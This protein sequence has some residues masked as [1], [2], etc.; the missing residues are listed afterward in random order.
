MWFRPTLEVERDQD[1]RYGAVPERR[2]DWLEGHSATP[3]AASPNHASGH[4]TAMAARQSLDL[5]AQACAL[6]SH[7]APERPLR[8]HPV[9]LSAH[10][11]IG[12]EA[13]RE[14]PRIA[15]LTLESWVGNPP[16]SL[17]SFHLA[18]R[19]FSLADEPDR[20][21]TAAKAKRN[22]TRLVVTSRKRPEL[23]NKLPRWASNQIYELLPL[24]IMVVCKMF[25]GLA[26][27]PQAWWRGPAP[28]KRYAKK[29]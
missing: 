2:T 7:S 20:K 13:I 4:S 28:L 16:G 23:W 22:P 27:S 6:V 10:R 17:A 29:T 15:D 19:G 21:K 8:C 1:L 12:L 24:G 14:R 26:R 3:P 11:T 25:G 5:A 18:Q 9:L